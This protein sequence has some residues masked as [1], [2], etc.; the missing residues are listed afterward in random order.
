MEF[1]NLKKYDP[2]IMDLITEEGNRQSSHI[3]LI[4]SE[5]F[6]SPQVMEAAGSNLTNKQVDIIKSLNVSE[7]IICLDK[8]Y[9]N[10]GDQEE[11]YFAKNVFKNFPLKI[12]KVNI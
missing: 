8:E 6:V 7:V 12:R 1:K 5:N 2:E 4:A 11:K 9:K 10:I 3:E